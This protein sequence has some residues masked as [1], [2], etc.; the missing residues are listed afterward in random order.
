M[1]HVGMTK[2]HGLCLQQNLKLTEGQLKNLFLLRR[3]YL[4]KNALL[5]NQQHELGQQLQLHATQHSGDSSLHTLNAVEI[6]HQMQ[7]NTVRLHEA[8]MQY[9]GVIYDGV[10]PYNIIPT[11]TALSC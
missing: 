5:V 7:D 1:T 4:Q 8:F 2:T 9:M 11:D 3:A 6:T 10:S